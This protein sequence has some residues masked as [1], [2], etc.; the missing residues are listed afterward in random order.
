M[1]IFIFCKITDSDAPFSPID[2]FFFYSEV[3]NHY[4][5]V[6]TFSRRFAN[7]APMFS[8]FHSAVLALYICSG[9]SAS[10]SGPPE[11][12]EALYDSLPELNITALKQRDRLHSEPISTTT[13]SSQDLDRAGVTAVK[14][15]SEMVPNLFIPDYG[16]RVTSS[17]YMRGLGARMEQPSVG[18]A[19]DNVTIL[20]KNA[21]DLD[22]PD[23]E[24]AE[25]FR[26]PQ[27]ALYGRNTM[28]GMINVSTLSPLKF[29]GWRLGATLATGRT[30][31]V[32]AGWYGKLH[33]S[34]GI[35]ISGLFNR[36]GGFRKNGYNDDLTENETSGSLRIKYI[37]RASGASSVQNVL[38]SSLLHQKGYAYEFVET[39][40]IDYNDPSRYKRFT[41]S[42]G[43]TFKRFH[44]RFTVVSVTALQYINDDLL[45]DQDFLPEDYF[46]L[47]QRQHEFSVSQDLITRS[48]EQSASAYTW[49]AGI[50]GFWKRMDMKAPVIF[51]NTGLAQL[52]EANRNKYNQ[53]YPISWNGREFPLESSFKVPTWGLDAYHESRLKL[54]DF[55][56]KGGIR[57]EYEKATM[58]YASVACLSYGIYRNDQGLPLPDAASIATWPLVRMVEEPIHDAGRLT[59]DY[60][61]ILPSVSAL[62]K[63]PGSSSNIYVTV[64]RGAKAGGFNTQMFS[65]VLQQRVMKVM[66]AGSDP[67]I[68]L[69]V[70]YKP[71][72]SWMH[73]VGTHLSFPSLFLEAEAALF[74][75]KCS[76]QQL[77]MF[78]PGSVTGRMMTNAGS[79]R[80]MGAEVTLRWSPGLG[81]NSNAS[82]G[83]TDARFIRFS[84]G[85]ESYA[86]KRL[87]YVPSNTLYVQVLKE[88]T[89]DHRRGERLT[90]DLNMKLAG[91]IEWNEANS[92]RQKTYAQ[93]GASVTWERPDW[94]LSLWGKNLTDTRYHT[95]YFKSMGHEFLQKGR[96]LQVGI[97]FSLKLD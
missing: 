89:V 75:I 83:F 33:E 39:G 32:S 67:D 5:L 95:F 66:G 34:H 14:G 69:T 26:G 97:N 2:I 79:T 62:W 48:P 7:F 59:R 81:W 20:N 85:R 64:A 21:Y 13:L 68:A 19:V 27:G 56:L 50:S 49:I 44:H 74:Y 43:I 78:P 12:L 25:V 88:F 52:I 96:P 87:P 92:L 35:S 17:I 16:S 94:S 53:R 28:G 6:L 82:Y 30:A 51:K 70:G 65:E 61:M 42:D 9:A 90:A 23:I 10:V 24:R 77:T 76:D 1:R 15:I 40:R 41:L 45:L 84:D 93:L 31:R 55:S 60:F 22:I 47:N 63:I 54:G 36:Q 73:E 46:T 86:G 8:R 71:E 3:L 29:Q 57:F 91:P 37:G 18:L 38:S 72:H 80:S 58:D 11:A 4:F